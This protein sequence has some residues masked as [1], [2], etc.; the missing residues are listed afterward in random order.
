MGTK[1]GLVENIEFESFK[2]H[3]SQYMVGHQDEVKLIYTGLLASWKSGTVPAFLIRGPPGLGKTMITQVIAE[4]FGADYVFT[5]TTLNTTEDEL[6]YKFLPSEKTK[7]GVKIQ[8][9][10]LPEALKKS[11]E[12]ITI[13]TIDEFDKTRPSTDALLLDFLQSARVS[14]RIDDQ[15]DV[16]VGDKK[17]LIVFLT[18][19]DN[20]EFSE[21][22]LRRLIV[23]NFKPLH[24]KEIE[25]LLRKHFD[26]ERVVRTLTSIY[27]AG[28]SAKLSKPVTV[29]ELIQLGHAMLTVPDADF[30]Q[31][32][33]SFVVKNVHDLYELQKA[34]LKTDPE[35]LDDDMEIPN[36]G[37]AML[38][39]LD[40]VSVGD[41]KRETKKETV[42]VRHLLSKIRLPVGKIGQ[43]LGDNNVEKVTDNIESTFNA[44]INTNTFSEYDEIIRTFKPE[45]AERPDVLG[46]FR[47][48][49]DDTLRLVSDKPLTLAELSKVFRR[50]ESEAYAED[51]VYIPNGHKDVLEL[52]EYYKELRFTYYTK[53]IMVLIDKDDENNSNPYTVL[54]LD[55]VRGRLYKVKLYVDNRNQKLGRKDH[56]IGLI[57]KLY[58]N[59]QVNSFAK[60]V[61]E[62]VIYE[63]GEKIMNGEFFESDD[64]KKLAGFVND[65]GDTVKIS[66]RINVNG[67]D[68]S[69]VKIR[70]KSRYDGEDECTTDFDVSKEYKGNENI[71]TINYTFKKLAV[72][73][74]LGRSLD[75]E[76]DEVDI[77]DDV[78]KIV[79][80]Y[81][82]EYG[83]LDG[84]K[85]YHDM[86]KEI[87]GYTKI[88]CD[89]IPELVT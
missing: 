44:S 18:S 5:Q 47:V 2:N 6:I 51:L 81:V 38:E 26:D 49:L 31:L 4:Y 55:R 71:Y 22:L 59:F 69:V 40:E 77:T 72:T 66:F 19:N 27:V 75:I 84:L 61:S 58:E 53:D 64:F 32:L 28:L 79:E 70:E 10:P 83:L 78:N 87:K 68:R 52:V 14:F 45:P 74:Y 39:K 56:Q 11:R 42:T 73:V 8:Y 50:M 85:V 16:I 3:I 15:E 60:R 29:Q 86:V 76:K 34:F 41:K 24:P 48:V 46:K 65:V 25:R 36:I 13:L 37:E 20:R 21:P 82:G 17:N 63:Y 80:K 1:T 35:D 23:I 62:N 12:K 67:D 43:V 89:K 9:G 7:S 54:R 88:I 57:D 30:N 33:L